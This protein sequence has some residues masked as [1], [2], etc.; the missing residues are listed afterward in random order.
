MGRN[1]YD[2]FSR[3]LLPLQLFDPGVQ[4]P[5]FILVGKLDVCRAMDFAAGS[6]WGCGAAAPSRGHLVFSA[7]PGK[8]ALDGSGDFSPFAEST[9]EPPISK[10]SRCSSACL[11]K[12][13]SVRTTSSDLSVSRNSPT[14]SRVSC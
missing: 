2:S 7:E 5:K 9:L 6:R 14:T 10:L 11:Q 1:N 8:K 4:S 3:D 12:Y 13:W